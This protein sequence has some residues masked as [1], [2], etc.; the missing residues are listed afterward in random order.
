MFGAA[1]LAASAGAATPLPLPDPMG[2]PSSKLYDYGVMGP[3]ASPEIVSS[4]LNAVDKPLPPGP[5]EPTWSS[6]AEHYDIPKWYAD[7]KFGIFIHWGVYSAAAHINEWYEKYMYNGDVAKWHAQHFGPI[8]T[9]GYKDLIPLFTAR[10]WDPDA[11]ALL[12]KEAGAKYV[13]PTAEHHD[14]FALWNSK[15]TPYNAVKMGPHRDLIGELEKSVHAQGLKFGVSN[16]G[17]ENFT[18]VNPDPEIDAKLRAEKAD[19]YDPKWEPFYHVADRSDAA[20]TVFLTDWVDRNL[21]LIDDY[22]PDLLWWDNGANLRLLDPLKRYVAAYYYN[23]AAATGQ[24]VTLSTKY[25][26][27]APSNDD[28]QQIGSVLDYEKVGIRSPKTIRETP[29]QVDDTV[30]TGP[31]GYVDGLETRPVSEIIDELVDTVSKGGNYLLNISPRADGVI[32]QNQRATLLGIGDWLKRNGDAI[33]ATRAWSQYGEGDWRFTTKDG[34]LYAIALKWPGEAATIKVLRK[35]QGKDAKRVYS[36]RLIGG[37]AV[38][39]TQDQ[40][41]LHLQ[42]PSKQPDEP[43]FAFKIEM[44]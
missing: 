20:M 16:H 35:P 18:F 13:I 25:V 41:G 39:F 17:V 1:L 34:A 24:K 33:Y 30:S 2:V 28:S 10:D 15:V 6:I 4:A 26:A 5:F 27:M 29:W 36:V 23:R 21:E 37:G 19:L 40:A 43:A 11:W 32:P 38:A 8:D 22:H 14:N 12:F 9:F 7:A 44:R 42:L 3:P 31:W